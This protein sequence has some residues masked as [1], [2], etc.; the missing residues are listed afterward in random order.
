MQVIAVGWISPFP[1]PFNGKDTGLGGWVWGQVQGAVEPKRLQPNWI[2][3]V[4]MGLVATA[5][6]TPPTSLSDVKTFMRNKQFRSLL[7]ARFRLVLDPVTGAPT[8]AKL[9]GVIMDGGWTPPFSFERFLAPSV[10]R[11]IPVL[12]SQPDIQELI[13][14]GWHRGYK[15]TITSVSTTR[16]PNS[17]LVLP[18]GERLL[19]DALIRFRAG[20]K[21][22]YTGTVI[23]SPY[24]VPWVWNEFAVTY[25]NG[26]VNVYGVASAFPTTWWFVN[27]TRIKCQPR[28]S[29][30]EWPLKR[31]PPQPTVFREIDTQRL[32]AYP[33][34]SI[35][36]P[37]TDNAPQIAD[38]PP[39]GPVYPQR[40]TV[41]PPSLPGNGQ[42]RYVM[43]D[44][45]L[46]SPNVSACG[47]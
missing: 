1:N 20:D 22:D 10:A 5:N 39:S 32:Q 9:T 38:T 3:Q 46:P 16:H 12:N 11:F 21:T 43:G 28:L 2:P 47:G 44:R 36:A 37:T 33:A 19:I 25:G 7:G 17:M 31:G 45:P 42:W 13:N 8:Q 18:P 40:F 30:S 27:G 26:Q 6:D 34:I 23:G 29:D 15:S 14:T 24:H 35:G 41:P 4:Y